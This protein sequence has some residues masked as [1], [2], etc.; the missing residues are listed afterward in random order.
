METCTWFNPFE[1]DAY[2]TDCG[3]G[4]TLIDGTPSDNSMK[5]CCFCGKPIVEKL[6][7]EE[8]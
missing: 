8:D 2:F 4:F 3:N 1:S 6:E 5:F 7:E